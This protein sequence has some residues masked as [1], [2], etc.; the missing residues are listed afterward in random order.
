MDPPLLFVD[1]PSSG[2]D[3]FMAQSVVTSL[4]DMA[5]SGRTILCTIHQPPSEVFAMFNR[6]GLVLSR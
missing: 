1:E 4:Q 5:K 2:L 3:S 6:Y